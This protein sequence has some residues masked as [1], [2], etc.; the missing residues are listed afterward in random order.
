MVV[1]KKSG[2]REMSIFMQPSIIK[3]NA[4]FVGAF[5]GDVE[6]IHVESNRSHAT[7]N[8]TV[9]VPEINQYLISAV[10]ETGKRLFFQLDVSKPICMYHACKIVFILTF[11]SITLTLFLLFNSSILRQ[12]YFPTKS[13]EV[14]ILSCPC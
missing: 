9:G 3:S 1:W 13:N 10:N 12:S 11:Q 14:G 8:L 5:K 4:F 2:L 7:W 6:A